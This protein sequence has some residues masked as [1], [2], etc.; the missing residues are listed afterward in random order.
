MIRHVTLAVIEDLSPELREI[1][2]VLVPDTGC[3]LID[4]G[5]AGLEDFVEPDRYP[6]RRLMAFPGRAPRP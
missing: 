1:A 4:D 3:R 5:V 6:R 2:A